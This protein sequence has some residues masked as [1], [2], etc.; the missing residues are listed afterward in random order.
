MDPLTETDARE[1][2]IFLESV[3]CDLS[4]FLHAARDSVSPAETQI[5]QKVRLGPGAFAD[6]RVAAGGLPPY[7]IEIDVGH[8]RSR[9][10]ES[11]RL[12]YAR[13]TPASEDAGKVIVV[14]DRGLASAS[15][16]DLCRSA[17]HD[18]LTRAGAASA[19][20]RRRRPVARPPERARPA[21]R[22]EAAR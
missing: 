19:D 18:P 11:M 5:H 4:R 14:V 16:R 13:R 6:I 21:I 2:R 1:L 8:S 9:V 22:H 15:E 20:R 12:K 7:F 10:I 3:L 17:E